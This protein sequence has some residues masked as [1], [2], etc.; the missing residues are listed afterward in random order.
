MM[1]IPKAKVA[2]GSVDYVRYLDAWDH[3]CEE[4]LKEEFVEWLPNKKGP[5]GGGNP[6]GP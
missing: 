5:Q 1:R 3:Y 6:G 4:V 2:A